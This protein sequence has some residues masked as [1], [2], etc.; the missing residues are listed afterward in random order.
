MK[1]YDFPELNLCPF[2][3]GHAIRVQHPGTNWDGKR[4]KG[5]NI[6]AGHGLWY[7]GCPHNFFE[8]MVEHCEICPSASWNVNLEDAENDWNKRTSLSKTKE[9][10]ND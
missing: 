9:I 10:S 2:C 1:I 4:D 6:G 7:V 8:T 3:G 5:I